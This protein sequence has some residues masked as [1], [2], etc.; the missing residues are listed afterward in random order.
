MA[1][2]GT[3]THSF[4]RQPGATFTACAVKIRIHFEV[5]PIGE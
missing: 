1:L 2:A 4:V 3:S 5:R